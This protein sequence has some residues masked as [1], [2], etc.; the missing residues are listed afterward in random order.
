M[1]ATIQKGLPFDVATGGAFPQVMPAPYRVIYDTTAPE[2]YG[3]VYP[4]WSSVMTC[5]ALF[6]GPV[7]IYIRNGSQIPTS[8]GT[9]TSPYSMPTS[10]VLS[11]DSFGTT[12][13]NGV[14]FSN[15]PLELKTDCNA[16]L[17]FQESSG[18]AT[19]TLSNPLTLISGC[20]IHLGAG[21]GHL[22]N[23]ASNQALTLRNVVV[24]TSGAGTL[25]TGSS[26]VVTLLEQTILQNNVLPASM[27]IFYDATSS[28][29]SQNGNLGVALSS[30]G[31]GGGAVQALIFQPGGTAS[32]NIYTTESSLMAAI[33]NDG[34]YTVFLDF[35]YVSDSFTMTMAWNLGPDATLVGLVHDGG[36]R[37]TLW[38]VHQFTLPLLEIRDVAFNANY[39]GLLFG[40]TPYTLILSGETFISTNNANAR[41]MSLSA[42]EHGNLYLRDGASMAPGE[43]NPL[44]DTSAGGFLRVYAAN[45]R[46]PNVHYAV[47]QY[48][49]SDPA[50]EIY[51]LT[52]AQIDPSYTDVFAW[53]GGGGGPVD[54]TAV[55]YEPG[56]PGNWPIPPSQVAAALDDL[57]ATVATSPDASVVTYEPGTPGN[58]PTPPTEVAAALDDLAAT[59]ATSPDAS[60][61]TYEPANANNWNYDA[62][63]PSFVAPALDDLAASDVVFVFR[64]LGTAGGNVYTTEENLSTAASAASGPV[65]ILFD[66][67]QV[68]GSYTFAGGAFNLGQAAIWTDGNINVN[69]YTELI[70]SNTTSLQYPPIEIQG[71]LNVSI[72]QS[73]P[74]C[75]LS[76]FATINLR[77]QA[78][79]SVAPA[80]GVFVDASA[81]E[82]G[83]TINLYDQASA[84]GMFYAGITNITAITINVYDRAELG[85]ITGS[86]GSAVINC[87]SF[88]ASIDPSFYLNVNAQF[89]TD[90]SGSATTTIPAA[91]SAGGFI[92]QNGTIYYASGNIHVANWIPISGGGSAYVPGDTSKWNTP[93]PTTI[94]QAIDRIA[95][96]VGAIT[97]IP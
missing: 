44:F 71:G 57:A 59:V 34:P 90:T 85:R 94:Q 37:P 77:D 63:V 9:F 45:T 15:S 2:Q 43:A 29:H 76:Q 65:T 31:G 97:P 39:N 13:P 80:M 86:P 16:L 83:V 96:V 55:T 33:G 92:L 89:L 28:P 41:M 84:G 22:I 72:Q 75:T 38:A 8:S 69:G 3:N 24:D 49:L 64:P 10:W 62:G 68:S 30:V 66:F 1:L 5:I 32:G 82:F 6:S 21:S 19:F 58:W 17:V 36:F 18:G 73:E 61:V 42:G 60:V 7:E 12:V 70:F 35:Q 81:S 95:A 40:T 47:P 78:V 79:I 52:S 11:T 74:V 93:Y 48:A 54:A 87:Y 26:N 23:G 46:N 91:A 56:T 67:S 20:V 14:Y 27:Q 88:A 51:A 50:T 25:A 4:S 53:S